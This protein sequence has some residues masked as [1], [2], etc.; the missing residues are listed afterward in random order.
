MSQRRQGD[1]QG[2]GPGEGRDVHHPQGVAPHCTNTMPFIKENLYI[3]TRQ[4]I[5]DELLLMGG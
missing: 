5:L 2:W 3:S 4:D 1:P